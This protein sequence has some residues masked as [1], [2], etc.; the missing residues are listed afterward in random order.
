MVI[1]APGTRDLK[2]PGPSV[3]K[4]MDL[5]IISFYPFSVTAHWRSFYSWLSQVRSLTHAAFSRDKAF[6]NS[7]MQATPVLVFS[8]FYI[9]LK[10]KEFDSSGR[11]FEVQKWKCAE[12]F[13]DHTCDRGMIGEEC[14]DKDWYP[15]IHNTHQN[16]LQNG[17]D[18]CHLF[19][20]LS[21]CLWKSHKHKLHRSTVLHFIKFPWWHDKEDT[22]R[23]MCD[24]YYCCQRLE[25][26]QCQSARFFCSNWT[27]ENVYYCFRSQYKSEKVPLK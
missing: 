13:G 16:T 19:L 17:N 8:C 21:C 11:H 27:G 12:K 5:G 15:V 3:L 25:A 18:G 10:A 24:V 22:W 4:A 23:Q 2:E 6:L 26:S 14:A 9:L 20:D 1:K 7:S